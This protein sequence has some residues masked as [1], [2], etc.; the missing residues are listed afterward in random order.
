MK[1][2]SQARK[3]W[4]MW[5][6]FNQNKVKKNLHSRDLNQCTNLFPC[7]LSID[8]LGSLTS[9]PWPQWQ[10]KLKH[11]Q[12]IQ[13]C[14]KDRHSWS[15]VE[16]RIPST[17]LGETVLHLLQ[18]SHQAN[19]SGAKESACLTLSY[20]NTQVCSRKVTSC[21]TPKPKMFISVWHQIPSKSVFFH[22]PTLP[23]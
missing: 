1:Q 4:T 13:V 19:D 15:Q 10:T 11:P 12:T 8:I 6:S 2:L 5:A 16:D 23:A 20:S 21:R 3:T 22:S 9:N 17:P 14:T 18:T 7:I